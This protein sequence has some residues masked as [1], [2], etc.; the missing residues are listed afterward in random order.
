[1]RYRTACI[2][3]FS[4]FATWIVNAQGPPPGVS[5]LANDAS[6][7]KQKADIIRQIMRISNSQD[8][9]NQI[10]NTQLPQTMKALRLN[11]LF[12]SAFL[13]QV[14]VRLRER[15]R[16]VDVGALAIP[17][18]SR[19]FTLEELQQILAFN[20]SQT[21]QK[22]ARLYPSIYSETAAAARVQGEEI[23]KEVTR[24][25]LVEHPEYVQQIQENHRKMQLQ[26][27][28]PVS[29]TI[30]APAPVIQQNE[31][32]AQSQGQVPSPDYQGSV[33]QIG[34]GVTPP[35]LISKKEAEY[36]PQATQ[37]KIQ[38]SVLLSIIID[39]KGI[40]R[41]VQVIRPLGLGLDEKAVEA[42]QQWRF[43]PG[44]KGG[45]PVVTQANVEVNFHML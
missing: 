33:Y 38:G 35:R 41:N 15:M 17:V 5:A 37:A 14:E 3:V 9:L 45:K 32:K 25:I 28:L 16:A 7:D 8:V 42:V 18:Y 39:E 24:E 30:T 43:W 31:G 13:D 34:N 44:T 20:Q 10:I 23:G 4:F 26:V 36:T 40:P 6:T 27:P 19:N 12:P 29:P 22:I 2:L 1:M 11:P 21:G